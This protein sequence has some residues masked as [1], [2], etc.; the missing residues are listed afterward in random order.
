MDIEDSITNRA[1]GGTAAQTPIVTVIAAVKDD[2]DN[3]TGTRV[4]GRLRT[5]ATRIS[6][7]TGADYDTSVDTF[8]VETVSAISFDDLEVVKDK[9]RAILEDEGYTIEEPIAVQAE[10]ETAT[11]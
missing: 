9:L 1:T 4:A 5:M 10:I 3:V 2:V 11:L 6:Y 8:G 7:V